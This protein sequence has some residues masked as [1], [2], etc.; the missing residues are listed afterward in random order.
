LGL[1]ASILDDPLLVPGMGLIVDFSSSSQ[2]RGCFWSENEGQTS[3]SALGTDYRVSSTG[4]CGEQR[5]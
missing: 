5:I 4:P 2:N 1:A 3:M